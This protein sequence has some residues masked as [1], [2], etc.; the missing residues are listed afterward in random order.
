ML[1]IRLS[2]YIGIAL[3]I[4]ANIGCSEN[5]NNK[6]SHNNVKAKEYIETGMEKAKANDH[7]GAIRDFSK[8][9]ELDDTAGKAYCLRAFTKEQLHDYSGALVDYDKSIELNYYLEF[10]YFRRGVTKLRLGRDESALED[11]NRSIE[12]NPNNGNAYYY[13]GLIKGIKKEYQ[14]AIEDFAKA[15]ELNPEDAD[16]YVERGKLTLEQAGEKYSESIN[17]GSEKEVTEAYD[18]ARL[19]AKK[20]FDMA[21]KINP[22][23]ASAYLERSKVIDDDNEKLANIN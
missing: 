23:H 5:G 17:T 1:A 3:L 15:I 11:I 13:R 19:D 14:A 9:I 4:I 10:S 22:N 2:L 8:A 12:L 18:K 21:I 7:R 20:D 16:A 6:T